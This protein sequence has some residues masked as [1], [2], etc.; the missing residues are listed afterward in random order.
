MKGGRECV[1]CMSPTSL[2]RSDLGTQLDLAQ[3][4][5]KEALPKLAKW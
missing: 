1:T 4:Y 5:F 2:T 3:M